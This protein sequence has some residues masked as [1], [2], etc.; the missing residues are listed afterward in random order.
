MF[1]SLKNPE[2]PI[3]VP[4]DKTGEIKNTHFDASKE[5]I[6]LVHG[7]GGNTSGP[8]VQKVKAAVAKVKL[9]VNVIGVDWLGFQNRNQKINVY[10][11][12]DFFGI[13]VAK[14]LTVLTKDHGL[15]LAKMTM[16]G[17][18]IAGKFMT[19]IGSQLKGEI[20]SI[21]GLETCAISR[22]DAKFVEVCIYEY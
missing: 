18:S 14:F 15:K 7:G 5:T 4:S 20:R 9:D 12:A 17:H 2:N 19:N 13:L 10:T 22:K 8:L 16:V 11:C 6:F 1:Y 3:I 21:V